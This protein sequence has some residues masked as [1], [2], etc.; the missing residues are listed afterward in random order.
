MGEPVTYTL[1]DRV[2]V[3]ALCNPP[4]NAL[5]AR[6][7]AG[8]L[9]AIE[10]A[11]EDALVDAVVLI[12]R[13]RCFS[14][15]ADIAEFGRP[16]P[17]GTPDL[18]QVVARVEA[19]PKPVVAA[20]HGTAVGGGLELAL[21]CH[22]R[23]GAPTARLGLPEV[24]LGLIPGAGGT[25]RLPRLIG[26]EPALGL[27]VGGQYC[28][29]TQSLSLG[30]IDEVV[31]DDLEAAAS[32]FAAQ[33]VADARPLRRLSEIEP[34]A[35]AATIDADLFERFRAG[36]EKRA[37]GLLA[38]YLCIDSVSNATRL[39]F[40]EAMQREREYFRRCLDSEQS[41]AQR[42]VFFAERQAA[43]IADVPADTPAADIAT[44]AVVGLGTMGIGIAMTFA[45][46]GIAVRVLEASPAALEKGL[47]AVRRTYAESVSRGRLAEQQMQERLAL[48]TGSVDYADLGDADIVIE[49]VFEDM[50]LKREVFAALDAHC[51]PGAILASNT[52]TLDI[53]EIAAATARPDKVIGTHF[54]SPAHV[55]RLMENVRGAATSKET[56][57]TVM[58]LSKTL[59]KLGVLVGVCDGFVGNRMLYAYTRQANLL[60]QE[61][62]LPQQVDGVLY[63]FGLPMGPFAV[64]DLAGLDVGWAVRRH[65][66]QAHPQE[67][68]FYL[69]ADRICER[70]RFGQ[71]TGAGWYRYEAGSRQPLPDPEVEALIREVS[72]ELGI[73]RRTIGDEEIRERCLYA[74]INEGARVLEEGVAQ[75]A[76]DIDVIWINGYGFPVYRGG[77]MFYAD[78]LGPRVICEALEAYHRANEFVPQP[79]PLLR[80]LARSGGGFHGG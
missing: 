43:K 18:P 78:R 29:A 27:I 33:A 17:A 34:A 14:A 46:A 35:L 56:V 4:V 63:D 75:R 61:G 38:P 52:S 74:L 45:N 20:I 71:K 80:E 3:I 5:G 39:A 16:A 28:D 66:A 51:R 10:R 50:A 26:V 79:A 67:K 72:A 64:G 48:I 22:H 30:L 37:R 68:R 58:R 77:P 55:M 31:E 36:I 49:A 73:E 40:A 53:D 19:C 11:G 62:A 9:A 13:G 2:A 1:R 15:G 25:Q 21:G 59:G 60:L 42:H 7:R 44:A 8:V 65:R 47:D 54:F 41:R 57:A 12:G 69:I 70:G 32:R 23:V 6:V 76:S 24:K